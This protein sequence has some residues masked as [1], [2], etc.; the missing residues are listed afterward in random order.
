MNCLICGES[1]KEKGNYHKSCLKKV[2]D[3]DETPEIDLKLSDINIEAQKMAGKLSIS[4]VQP[5]VSVRLNKEK[6]K[7]EAAAEGGEYILKPQSQTF[8]NLPENEWTCTILARK[9]EIDVPSFALIKLKDESLA[10]IVKRFDRSRGD[11]IHVEDFGQ[12]LEKKDKYKGSYEEIGKKLKT[13][14]EIPGLD[15]QLLFE[16]ILFYYIIGNGDAHLKNFSIRYEDNGLIRLAP[17][18]DIVS[19]KI[20]I[21]DEED[22]ALTLNGKKNNIKKTDFYSFNGY[23]GINKKYT[24]EVFKKYINSEALLG[25]IVNINND[26]SSKLGK[27]IKERVNN[28]NKG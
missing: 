3:T 17:A 20:L 7:I 23:L 8:Y 26:I 27:I 28:F 1:F 22:F 18:Y 6:N 13:I 12:I 19:S 2:F 15:V 5:K 21:K 9:M 14:S 10:Y 4:G 16:R 25:G 24:D 11:K